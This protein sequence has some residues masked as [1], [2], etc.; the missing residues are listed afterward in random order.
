MKNPVARTGGMEGHAA[1]N[2]KPARRGWARWARSQRIPANRVLQTANRLPRRAAASRLRLIGSPSGRTVSSRSPDCAT[3]APSTGHR[4]G[5]TSEPPR[6]VVATTG[7]RDA[8]NR[9]RTSDSAPSEKIGNEPSTAK[10]NPHHGPSERMWTRPKM[11]AYRLKR[12]RLV[13]RCSRMS[14]LSIAAFHMPRARME[15]RGPSPNRLRELGSS[16]FVHRFTRSRLDDRLPLL[17][18][19]TCSH[20][21]RFYSL[22]CRSDGRRRLP[23]GLLV[24]HQRPGDA[25]HSI[26]QRHRD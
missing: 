3:P 11:Q 26:R 9:K 16:P 17:Y 20:S 5:S 8:P 15:M 7:T 2:R 24:R 25:R 14:G 23:V 22:A 4:A 19:P 10:V 12:S 21:S 1:A 18:P 13:V 6:D